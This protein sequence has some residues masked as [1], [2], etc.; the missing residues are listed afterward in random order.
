MVVI[1]A[2]PDYYPPT[3][4]ALKILRRYFQVTIIARNMG[5]RK[6]NWGDIEIIRVGD[7]ESPEAKQSL[8]RRAKLAELWRFCSAVRRTVAQ[9]EPDA[10]YAYDIHGFVAALRVPGTRRMPI[11]FQM[12]E[13]P[14]LTKG[15]A[16]SLQFWITK[17]ALLRA[18]AASLVVFPEQ[19]RAR[20]WRQAARDPRP[21]LIVPNCS[22]LD[23]FSPP[24]DFREL[25]RKR[26]AARRL[27]YIGW[28]SEV[29]GQ[30]EAVRA[31]ALTGAT[32]SITLVGP[33]QSRFAAELRR[34]AENLEVQSRVQTDPWVP[35][36]EL[37]QRFSACAVGLSLY[38]PVSQ[39]WEFNSS[40]TNKLFEYA[41]LGIPAVVPDRKSYREFFADDDWVVYADPADPE[42][43]AR[44]IEYL[45]ADRERYIAMS[46][47]ARHAH[48]TKYNY[49]HVFAPVLERII[50]LT[51]D[52]PRREAAQ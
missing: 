2:N 30:A 40:A 47:A 10:M 16:R 51:G 5:K 21:A 23:F 19:N 49:E 20:I 42:S 36:T 31:L 43:I 45:L 26:F 1:Y 35:H 14:E 7:Y 33:H 28:M 52:V 29:N 13:L 22:S 32:T 25:A 38:R 41:A 17:Y 11:I 27:L 24:R 15:S 4:N 39:N 44:A 48:E 37:T 9:R 8:S 3:I 50:A 46:L 34:L 6:R 12:H 18:R